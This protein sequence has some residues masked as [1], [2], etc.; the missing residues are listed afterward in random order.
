MEVINAI[1]EENLPLLES[2][3][4]KAKARLLSTARN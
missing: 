1:E 4:V 3:L 2:M